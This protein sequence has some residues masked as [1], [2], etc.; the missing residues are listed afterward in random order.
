MKTPHGK[1]ETAGCSYNPH[2]S[3]FTALT[4]TKPPGD[5]SLTS[6]DDIQVAA[7]PSR[8][9][10]RFSLSSFLLAPTHVGL[11]G[12][13]QLPALCPSAPNQKQYQGVGL[14]TV[15]T[16]TMMLMFSI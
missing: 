16:K 14:L 7:C 11:G 8:V 6:R 4:L 9:D 1:D 5:N 15:G 2:F 12:L 10:H 3:L 13:L